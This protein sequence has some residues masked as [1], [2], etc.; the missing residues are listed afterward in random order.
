MTR[1]VFSSKNKASA[2]SPSTNLLT[3]LKQVNW[4]MKSLN[5]KKASGPDQISNFVL[6]CLSPKFRENLTVI[7]NNC[8]NNGNFPDG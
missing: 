3:D 5:T 4:I 1:T 7:M 2:P 8:L 6:K